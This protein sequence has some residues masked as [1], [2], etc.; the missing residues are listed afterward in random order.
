VSQISR[1]LSACLNH[2]IPVWWTGTVAECG[3]RGS[4]KGIQNAVLVHRR[5]IRMVL[6]V[7]KCFADII[8]SWIILVGWVS[9]SQIVNCQADGKV[10]GGSFIMFVHLL[11]TQHQGKGRKELSKIG[12]DFCVSVISPCGMT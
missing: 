6:D 10:M 12:F 9:N 1:E 3:I 5:D 7:L 2:T 11:I 8:V 4:S